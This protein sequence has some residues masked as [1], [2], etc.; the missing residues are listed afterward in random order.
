MALRK[1]VLPA[2]LGPMMPKISPCCTER[3]TLSTAV[4]RPKILVRP[5]VA[6][7]AVITV[8]LR[9]GQSGAMTALPLP[10]PGTNPGVSGLVSRRLD[11]VL[12][13]LGRPGGFGLAVEVLQHR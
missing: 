3:D 10:V 6:R 7:M 1:V 9:R 8:F 4:R 5:V 2:P 13:E 12:L 11:D